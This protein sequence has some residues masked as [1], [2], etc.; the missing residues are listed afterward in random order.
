L[1]RLRHPTIRGPDQGAL[2]TETDKAR[3]RNL[4]KK[5][6]FEDG[7]MDQATRGQILS[8]ALGEMGEEKAP[9]LPAETLEPAPEAEVEAAPEEAAAEPPPEPKIPKRRLDEEIRKKREAEQQAQYWK[10]RAEAVVQPQQVQA[11]DDVDD[12]DEDILERLDRRL[13]T[14]ESRAVENERQLALDREKKRLKTEISSAVSDNPRADAQEVAREML[15]DPGISAADAARLVQDREEA[16]E[17]EILKK[18]SIKKQQKAEA[19]R[20]PKTTGLPAVPSE[21]KQPMTRDSA[22]RAFADVF[23][24]LKDSSA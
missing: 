5:R 7:S 6:L 22:K 14:M 8:A 17:T 15:L 9:E 12:D 18:H 10:G 20:R 4:D 2:E 11:S 21:E 3:G 13:H 23:N 1:D 16:R 24:R 19:A